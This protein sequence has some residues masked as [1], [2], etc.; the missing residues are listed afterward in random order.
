M[1]LI[2]LVENTKT[3][4]KLVLS[5]YGILSPANR[6]TPTVSNC[7]ESLSNGTLQ[8][9]GHIAVQLKPLVQRK[10]MVQKAHLLSKE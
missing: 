10:L 2:Y 6:P 4:T 3:D 8:A 5:K 9:M 1:S 7:P